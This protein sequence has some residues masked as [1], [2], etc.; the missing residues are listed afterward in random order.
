MISNVIRSSPA[1]QACSQVVLGYPRSSWLSEG[2][3]EKLRDL[4]FI[5]ITTDYLME[6][7]WAV[8]LGMLLYSHTH[9]N[10]ETHEFN[11][12]YSLK[13]PRELRRNGSV[14]LL[15]LF[16]HLPDRTSLKELR[17]SSVTEM[18]VG[19]AQHSCP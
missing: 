16:L 7:V 18:R 1:L 19:I 8:S 15:L 11:S 12:T 5:F 2:S 6:S 13:N 17:G 4:L 10:A 9:L 3:G 14:F